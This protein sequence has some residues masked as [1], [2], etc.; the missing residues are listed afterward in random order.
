MQCLVRRFVEGAPRQLCRVPDEAIDLTRPE[1]ARPPQ[2]TQDARLEPSTTAAAKRPR[3][4]RPPSTRT[5][6]AESARNM[7]KSILPIG[8]PKAANEPER[9]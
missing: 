6:A 7:P 9:S 3:R 8:Q 2:V 1:A 5:I 4:S